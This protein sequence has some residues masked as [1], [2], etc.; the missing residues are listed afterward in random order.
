MSHPPPVSDNILETT[1][2]WWETMKQPIAPTS[3]VNIYHPADFV[4]GESVETSTRTMSFIIKEGKKFVTLSSLQGMVGNKVN[5]RVIAKKG[6]NK[7]T[8]NKANN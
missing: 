1:F 3:K 4:E 5:K 7:V 6:K 2:E 8:S